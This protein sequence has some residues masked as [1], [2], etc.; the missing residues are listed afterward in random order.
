LETVLRK[1]RY[2]NSGTLINRLGF[3]G[4]QLG[5]TES[6]GHMLPDEGVRL[7]KK[8]L[9]LGVNFFDTAPGYANGLSERIIGEAVKG[10]RDTVVINTKLGHKADG[11]VDFSAAALEGQI[12]ESLLRLETDYLDSVLLHNPAMEILRGE[13]DHFRELGR[14]KEKGLIRAFGVSIDTREELENALN[15]KI[16]VVEILFNVFF[17]ETRP[18]F[19]KAREKNIA[20]IAKVPLDSGW[21]TGKYDAQSEFTGVRTRW[22]RQTIERRAALVKE[23]EGITKSNEIAKFALSFILSFPEMTAVI[24]GINSEQNLIRNLRYADFELPEEMKQAM[25]DLYDSRINRNPLPW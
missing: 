16:D 19:K 2:A 20:L 24:P 5:N 6:W 18:L 8:A 7:V 22:D 23:L 11:T 3:G 15:R 9:R 14:L 25:M 21:L 12:T 4:W 13:T 1:A 10:S 17:Q